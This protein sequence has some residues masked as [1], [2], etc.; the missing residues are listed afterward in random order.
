MPASIASIP[1]LK[2]GTELS[3]SGLEYS[4]Y[5]AMLPHPDAHALRQFLGY[6]AGLLAG[7]E[8]HEYPLRSIAGNNMPVPFDMQRPFARP[9]HYPEPSALRSVQP[10][11]SRVRDQRR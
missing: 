2:F 7:P 5:R 9:R 6:L 8:E 11:R 1:D 4:V 3:R 10:R